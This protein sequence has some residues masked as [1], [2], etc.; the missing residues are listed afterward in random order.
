MYPL[1][2]KN[3]PIAKLWGGNYLCENFSKPFDVDNL[4]GES[5][6]ISGYKD[7]LTIVENGYFKGQNVY[8]VLAVIYDKK[9]SNIF[10]LLVKFLD[11]KKQLSIQ[12]HPSENYYKEIKN[13]GKGKTE[14]W[15]VLDTYP[16]AEVIC[17]LK[18]NITRK[19]FI[20]A[21]N[22]ND[23]LS[24][25]N[26]FS[27]QKD[28]FI[29]IPA[30]TIHSAKGVVVYEVMQT[31]DTSYRI[32]DFNNNREIHIEDALSVI[33]FD[34]VFPWYLRRKKIVDKVNSVENLIV[35]EYFDLDR[36]IVHNSMLFNVPK[37]YIH[38]ITNIEGSVTLIVNGIEHSLKVGETVL[39]TDNLNHYILENNTTVQAKILRATTLL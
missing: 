27:V 10:P 2:F 23:I 26:R 35:S 11:I 5:W 17:G 12:V 37:K 34:N 15:Y 21:I 7:K 32:N 39:L 4:I 31:S 6:E 28:D 9:Y 33:N 29:F 18:E 3:I 22:N 16:D 36:I 14:C 30:G 1:K 19:D 8:D 13:K 38:I 20:S 24:C 25:V